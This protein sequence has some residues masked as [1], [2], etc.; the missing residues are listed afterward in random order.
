M[1]NDG[2][3]ETRETQIFVDVNSSV[4]L[5]I[6]FDPDFEDNKYLRTAESKL[7]VIYR[8]HPSTD[9][10]W[11]SGDVYYPNLKFETENVSVLSKRKAYTMHKNR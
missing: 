6:Q 1:L 2:T 9:E 10:V 8:D 11:L 7:E 4:V 5:L 3:H